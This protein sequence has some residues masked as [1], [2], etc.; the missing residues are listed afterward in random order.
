ML[1]PRSRVV[2][3]TSGLRLLA[4]DVRTELK[5][6]AARAQLLRTRRHLSLHRRC[7]GVPDVL[8]VANTS[9]GR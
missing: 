8:I 7:H 4:G 1:S 5:Y 3:G 6:N 2:R 9:E